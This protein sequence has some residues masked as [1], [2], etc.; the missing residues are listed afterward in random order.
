MLNKTRIEH[1]EGSSPQN[2]PAKA[3]YSYVKSHYSGWELVFI[4]ETWEWQGEYVF[5]QNFV[6]FGFVQSSH[7]VWCKLKLWFS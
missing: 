4:R 3:G 1:R 6:I 7:V 5:I 2:T